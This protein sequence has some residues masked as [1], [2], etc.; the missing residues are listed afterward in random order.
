MNSKGKAG[1]RQGPSGRR[2]GSG[3]AGL[4]ADGLGAVCA[5]LLSRPR[6]AAAPDVAAP[7]PTH[8]SRSALRPQK[9]CGAVWSS[10]LRC[11]RWGGFSVTDTGWSEWGARAGIW[12]G[13]WRADRGG[14]PRLEQQALAELN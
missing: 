13:Q 12:V 10:G 1:K 11:V 6:S 3:R 7:S 14:A 4:G 8:R 5:V 9:L 2:A